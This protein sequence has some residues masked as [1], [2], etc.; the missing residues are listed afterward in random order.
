MA[1]IYIKGDT[2]AIERA[3]R[4]APKAARAAQISAVN[5]IVAQAQTAGVRELSR[6]VRLPQKI[7]KQ[8]VKFFKATARNFAARLLTLT[9]GVPIDRLTYRE[10]K[11][12][13]VSAAGQRFPHAFRAFRASG[14][15][16]Q[17][18]LVFERVGRKR[19]PIERVKIELN[20]DADQIFGRTVR[21]LVTTKLPAVFERELAFRLSRQ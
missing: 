21:L 12:G 17:A 5:K 2:K 6:K 7:I 10:L 16:R 20:P 11:K 3:L 4:E 1:V 18:R 13:G 15:E 8:R 14:N 19:L 9:A